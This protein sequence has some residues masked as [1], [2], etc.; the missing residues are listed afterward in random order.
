MAVIINNVQ[1]QVAINTEGTSANSKSILDVNSSSLGIL[2]PRISET[3]MNNIVDPPISLT[4]YN[5]TA[6]AFY[7]FNGTS[8]I[9][10]N[11]TEGTWSV[12]GNNIY[13]SVSGNIGIGTTSPNQKL[14][15]A[16]GN[17]QLDN[18]TTSNNG[19]I[20]KDLTPFIHNFNYG[21]N[22]AFTT[23]GGNTF[24]GIN[25]G[26]L[27]MGQS[28]PASDASSYNTAVG[29]GTLSQNTHGYRNSMLGYKALYSN[30]EGYDN[31]AIG[32]K[33][34]YSNTLGYW[35]TAQG[36]KTLYANLTGYGNSTFG[37]STFFYSL[38]S[39]N[40]GFGFHAGY[41]NTGNNN[42]AIG[43]YSLRASSDRSNNVAIG[44]N[45]LYK[46]GEGATGTDE[47]NY[48]TAV[49]SSS[50][51][52]NTKGYKN[53][54]VGFESLYS[55][56]DAENNTAMG[57]YS[58]HSNTTGDINS[59]FGTEALKANTTG[60]ANTAIGNQSLGENTTGGF[61]TSCG[62]WSMKSNT[63]GGKNSAF[64]ANVLKENTTGTNNS[65]FGDGALQ[66]NTT[67]TNNS[68]FGSGALYYNQTGSHNTAIGYDA[69][70]LSSSG[71]QNTA[72]GYYSMRSLS[73]GGNNTAVG[74]YSGNNITS[75]NQNIA[76]GYKAYVP[77]ASA[78]YQLNIGNLIYGTQLNGY[79]NIISDGKIGIGT[80]APNE[81]FEVANKDHGH[82]RMVVSDGNGSERYV[83]LFQSP[84]STYAN[85]RI[86]TYKYG[87]GVG[88][89]SLEINTVGDA[90]TIFGG[91]IITE[92]HKGKNIGQDGLAWNKVYCDDVI[93]QGTAAFADRVVSDEIVNYPPK[94][95]SEGDF[96]YKTDKSLKELD[97][98]SL[99]KGLREG[100]GVL[101]G[102]MASYNYKTNYEQQLLINNLIKE[103]SLLKVEINELKKK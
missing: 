18:T 35:N 61:N 37:Y 38:G 24:V 62:S 7:Y 54:A 39:Y 6:N 100:N 88:G 85:G 4:L 30:T 94:A 51:F 50:L 32:F 74:Y 36:F 72:L 49:G 86:E 42:V 11:T 53:S 77:T 95:K 15:I 87:T 92:T 57:Y 25:S 44:Y 60:R 98:N 101:T 59:A 33:S 56:T 58:L 8:W 90:S 41:G 97:P 31:T 66:E 64:G 82:G 73:S 13:S 9:P 5:T 81:T 91:D 80:T 3:E 89:C 76:I 102:E 96:D 99:P 55:N 52:G 93:E 47:G 46:N 17:I 43:A 10:V 67:G 83:I 16:N 14:S 23:E 40:S 68:G 75:G 103:I 34:L 22:G 78:W 2:I 70:M 63:E 21:Y 84:A 12:S 65:G 28:A 20:Y 79:E 29:E 69:L 26:N 45:T 19:I 48:N 27:T 1:S 71:Q